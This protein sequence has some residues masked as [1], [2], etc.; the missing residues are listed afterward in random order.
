M[1]SLLE[2][3]GD[4]TEIIV[5]DG[6]SDDGTREYLDSLSLREK[7]VIVIDNPLLHASGGLNAA[8]KKSRGEFIIRMDAHT[9]YAPDYI[10]KSIE[11]LE[12]TGAD[13]AGGPQVAE[14]SGGYV[15]RAIAAACH[16]SIAVGGSSIHDPRYEGPTDS[17]IYGCWRRSLFA[18]VGLFDEDLVRN[19]DGEHNRR[20]TRAGGLIWQTPDIRSWYRPRDNIM[21]VARQYAQYGY[22]KAREIQKSKKVPSPRQI[23]PGLFLLSIPVLAATSFFSS[24]T[25]KIFLLIISAYIVF[26]AGS[27]FHLCLASGGWR[28]FIL[29]PPVF[30]AMQAGYGYGSIRGVIDFWIMGRK[31]REGFAGLTR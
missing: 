25:L 16:S 29:F 10:E 24:V 30:F 31:G 8:I 20:I 5:A 19:Q 13:N 3:T 27:A 9:R 17:V 18:N 15:A 12:K 11:T 21:A 1:R 7:R 2:M 22:W 4:E 26:L 23:V 28:Y 14:S 6:R